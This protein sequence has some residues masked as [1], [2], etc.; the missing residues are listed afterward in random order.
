[1]LYFIRYRDNMGAAFGYEKLFYEDSFY[2]HDSTSSK[3]LRMLIQAILPKRNNNYDSPTHSIVK[4]YRV[5]TDGST[6]YLGYVAWNGND[7]LMY[8]TDGSYGFLN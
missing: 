1:M 4:Y 7:L 5:N 2:T 8:H 6:T 3:T